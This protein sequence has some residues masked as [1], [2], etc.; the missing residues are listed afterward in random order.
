VSYTFFNFEGVV[1]W[2]ALVI[3]GIDYIATTHNQV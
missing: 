1:G 3:R 2:G